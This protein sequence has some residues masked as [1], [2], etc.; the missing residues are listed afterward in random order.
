M[1]MTVH[2]RKLFLNEHNPDPNDNEE[3]IGDGG[4]GMFVFQKHMRTV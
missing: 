2:R 4:D 3:L 1:L